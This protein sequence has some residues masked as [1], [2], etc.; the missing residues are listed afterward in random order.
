MLRV[1]LR[2]PHYPRPG[3]LATT[4][5]IKTEGSHRTFFILGRP[6]ASSSSLPSLRRNLARGLYWHRRPPRADSPLPHC[7]RYGCNCDYG[8]CANAPRVPL[9]T[10]IRGGWDSRPPPTPATPSRTRCTAPT[11]CDTAFDQPIPRP[12]ATQQPTV[13]RHGRQLEHDAIWQAYADRDARRLEKRIARR[14]ASARAAKKLRLAP[15][16]YPAF[17]T[18]SHDP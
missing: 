17:R 1:R 14:R 10:H 5:C 3:V 18:R 6:Q 15:K 4:D 12:F 7:H 2:S 9:R 13:T 16:D 11:R 8:A